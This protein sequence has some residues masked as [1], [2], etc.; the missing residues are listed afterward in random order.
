MALRF[1]EAWGHFLVGGG[2]MPDD[3]PFFRF[4]P[5]AY[6][7]GSFIASERTC[8]VC[9]RASVWRYNASVHVAGDPPIVCARCVAD[10]RLSAFCSGRH[11]MH[12]ADFTED[13]ADV[14]AEEVMQRTPGFSTFNAFEWPASRGKPMAYI[15]HGDEAATWENP[16]AARAIRKL[17]ADEGDPLEGTTPYALVFREIDGTRHVAIMDHD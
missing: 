9:R 14:L 11:V 12:D 2:E 4:H 3:K 13:I 7:R 15:G 8:Q 1:D 16:A 5:G 17:Y 10:G 6:E